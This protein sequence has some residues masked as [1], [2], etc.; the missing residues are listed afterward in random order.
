MA[1]A[2]ESK[3]EGKGEATMEALGC[4]SAAERGRREEGGVGHG[5][6]RSLRAGRRRKPQKRRR[7]VNETEGGKRA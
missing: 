4:L 5:G 3:A 7:R 2:E 6:P 1:T